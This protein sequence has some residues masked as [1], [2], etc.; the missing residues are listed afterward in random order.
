MKRDTTRQREWQREPKCTERR[1]ETKIAQ[2]GTKQIDRERERER[3]SRSGGK[4]FQIMRTAVDMQLVG[5]DL[6]ADPTVLQLV[7]GYVPMA[8]SL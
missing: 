6:S 2:T 1:T 3:D 5:H 7:F 8:L 4:M